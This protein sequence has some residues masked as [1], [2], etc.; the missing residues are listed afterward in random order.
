M[1]CFAPLRIVYVH[2]MVKDH[3]LAMSRRQG[4]I[5]GIFRHQEGWPAPMLPC[6]VL[7]RSKPKAKNPN[8]S[9]ALSIILVGCSKKVPEREV[10]VVGLGCGDCL[11]A[12]ALQVAFDGSRKYEV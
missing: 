10:I 1:G 4:F 6:R 3:E 7:R 8:P 2:I 12:L 5:F 9:P 11:M